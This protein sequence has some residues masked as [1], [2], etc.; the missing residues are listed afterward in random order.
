MSTYY[1]VVC[2]PLYSYEGKYTSCSV[3]GPAELIYKIGKITKPKKGFGPILAFDT[4]EHAESFR[5]HCCIMSFTCILEGTGKKTKLRQNRLLSWA[6]SHL[7]KFWK[8]KNQSY[9]KNINSVYI[10]EGWP[11]GTVGLSYFK[12][13]KKI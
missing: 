2:S 10:I 3:S 6:N 1:K 9:L 8:T 7:R 13:E 5:Q 11:I 4:L 12:P